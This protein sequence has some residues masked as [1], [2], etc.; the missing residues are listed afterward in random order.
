M[1]S[2]LTAECTPLKKEYDACFNGWFEGYLE[3][4]SK[5]DT[6]AARQAIQVERKAEQ[7]EK[8]CGALWASYRDCVHRAVESKGLMQLLNDA[9]SENPLNKPIPPPSQSSSSS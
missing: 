1:A 2:S 4:V 7:Y 8:N 5:A 6:P 9:R 3:P